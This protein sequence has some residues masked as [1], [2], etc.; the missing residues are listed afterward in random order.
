MPRLL[1]ACAAVAAVIHVASG[2]N[3]GGLHLIRSHGASLRGRCARP[4]ATQ[5]TCQD[6]GYKIV[7]SQLE[8]TGGGWTIQGV[9]PVGFFP[10]LLACAPR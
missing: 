8:G 3:G 1:R 2:F 6:E 7:P 5:W 9:K 10:A 4:A